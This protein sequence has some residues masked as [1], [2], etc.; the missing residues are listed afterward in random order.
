M[1]KIKKCKWLHNV[2]GESLISDVAEVALQERLNLVAYY[3]PLVAQHAEDDVEYVHQIRVA[4]RRSQAA[5]ELFAPLLPLKR[6][7][8]L[9]ER[10]KK[11]RRAAGNARDLDVFIAHLVELKQAIPGGRIKGSIKELKR[12]RAAEQPHLAEI[13]NYAESKN[14]QANIDDIIQRVRWRDSNSEES[15]STTAPGYLEPVIGEFFYQADQVFDHPEALHELRIEGKRLRYAMELTSAAFAPSFKE[16]LY[17]NLEKIQTKLGE[18]N[19]HAV[20]QIKL[21]SWADQTADLHVADCLGDIIQQHHASYAESTQQFLEWWS[22]KTVK[23]L[24][25]QFQGYLE[26]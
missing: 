4:V 6:T 19:D 7:E 23:G 16:K 5:L 22:A 2:T 8:K 21:K 1:S 24:K 9:Q 14:L 20:A 25:Q 3:V 26:P 12:L 11:I 13:Q 10:L 18:I 15:L 17:P